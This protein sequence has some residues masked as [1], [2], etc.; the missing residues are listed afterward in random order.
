[1]DIVALGMSGALLGVQAGAVVLVG[2]PGA[3]EGASPVNC[4]MMA[5]SERAWKARLTSVKHGLKGRIARRPARRI[6]TL[7]HSHLSALS[8]G[9]LLLC[10]GDWE[11]LLGSPPLLAARPGGTAVAR[12]VTYSA[13]HTACH[14]SHL[15]IPPQ[16]EYWPNQQGSPHCPRCTPHRVCRR[17]AQAVGA[18]Q[19]AP[20]SGAPRSRRTSQPLLCAPHLCAPSLSPT[21]HWTFRVI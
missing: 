13:G 7:N 19:A 18:W 21:S 9:L 11:P 3:S 5:S 10:G 1:M 12:Y 15:M 20:A 16:L 8:G 17:S 6:A 2:S 4:Q 14:H